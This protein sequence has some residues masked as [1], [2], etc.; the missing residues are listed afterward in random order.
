MKT[1]TGSDTILTNGSYKPAK[2]KNFWPGGKFG[3]ADGIELKWDSDVTCANGGTNSFTA[4]I[5][6]DKMYD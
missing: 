6:C 4:I 5:T 1:D 3:D 2:I